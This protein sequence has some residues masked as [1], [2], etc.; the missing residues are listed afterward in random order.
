MGT[1]RT[2]WETKKSEYQIYIGVGCVNDIEDCPYS[3]EYTLKCFG[4]SIMIQLTF[5]QFRKKRGMYEE[6]KGKETK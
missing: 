5:K 2:F 6:R 3:Q 1:T 4:N